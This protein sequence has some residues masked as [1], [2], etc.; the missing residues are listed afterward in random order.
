MNNEYLY[1]VNREQLGQHWRCAV[2]DR[3]AFCPE[4]WDKCSICKEMS[5][6]FSELQ[7]SEFFYSNTSVAN[8]EEVISYQPI[9]WRIFAC[10]INKSNKKFR[11]EIAKSIP[12][13]DLVL[14]YGKTR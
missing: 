2:E 3:D 14:N 1:C 5:N 4:K 13:R 11:M 10:I 9:L 6:V 7:D 12:N 8:N